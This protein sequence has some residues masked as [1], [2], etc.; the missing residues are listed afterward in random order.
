MN[1]MW[2][3][4]CLFHAVL[5]NGN[6]MPFPGV[7]FGEQ[8]PKSVRNSSGHDCPLGERNAIILCALKIFV[9]EFQGLVI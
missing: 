6:T 3:R 2:T 1:T 9:K 5:V 7:L 8:D 4:R